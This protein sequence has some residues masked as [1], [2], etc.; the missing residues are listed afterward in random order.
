MNHLSNGVRSPRREEGS[1]ALNPVAYT[2]NVVRS[3][4]RYQ[5]APVLKALRLPEWRG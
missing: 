1:T 4:L 5:L 2:D 3:F